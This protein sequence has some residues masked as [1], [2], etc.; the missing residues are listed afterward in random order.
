MFAALG[1][2]VSRRPWYVV[3]AWVVLAVV[4]VSL[5]PALQTTTDEAEFLPDKYE[6]IKAAKLQSD[7]F[8]GATTPAAILVFEREDGEQLTDDDQAE[9]AQISEELGPKLPDETFVQEVVTVDPEGGPNLSEDGLVQIGIIGLAEGSTGFDTQA[10][11]DGKKL[12]DALEPLVE[13]SDL[14]VLTT[15]SVPQSLD[16]QESSEQTLAIVGLATVLLIVILL[17]LIFRSVIICLMPI[18]VVF[19][20]GTIA[21]GLIAWANDA[22]RPQGGLLDR[23]DPVRRPLRH[24]HRLH[25]VL[26]VPL[27]RAAAAGRGHARRRRTRA[28]SGPVRPS[29][30]PAEPSSSRSWP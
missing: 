27:P 4:V 14:N 3:G 30:R 29:R 28:W 13:D 6:S 18:L 19:L 26:P 12:R 5:A 17:A 22:V 2:F 7:K 21:T 1:R 23:G 25:P 24:R 10:I 11:D 20:A 16:S 15:G 8:P 9:V